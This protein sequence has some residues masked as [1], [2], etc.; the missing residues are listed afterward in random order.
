MK[1]S[2]SYALAQSTKLSVYEKRVT[3]VVLETKNL[4]E[5]RPPGGECV[6]AGRSGGV[7]KGCMGPTHVCVVSVRE[8]QRER[9]RTRQRDHHQS[10]TNTNTRPAD[11]SCHT[12][13]PTC[14]T[15]AAATAAGAGGARRGRHQRPRHCAAHRQGVPA[16]ER[17]QP[18][19]QCAGHARVLLARTRLLPGA[20]AAGGADARPLP[21][22]IAD[23]MSAASP[24]SAAHRTA[25]T[26][27]ALSPHTAVHTAVRTPI[28]CSATIL[29]TL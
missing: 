9:Q 26:P 23:Y 5:V 22:L 2:I 6:V 3:D 4:P 10:T 25:T 27:F 11:T 21:P 12:R 14:R 1:L 18:A 17:C 16:E 29:Q 13:L 15:P 28:R 24:A 19:G 20:R 7:V 8:R